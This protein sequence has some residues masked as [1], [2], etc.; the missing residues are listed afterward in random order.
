MTVLVVNH[1]IIESISILTAV[2]GPM[3]KFDVDNQRDCFR[4][5]VKSTLAIRYQLSTLSVL[6]LDRVHHLPHALLPEKDT[7]CLPE[8]NQRIPNALRRI[9]SGGDHN[10][11]QCCP[12]PIEYNGI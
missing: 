5:E 2:I 4:Q 7:Y 8:W 12:L 10:A 1:G 9:Q 11:L 3:I 6:D